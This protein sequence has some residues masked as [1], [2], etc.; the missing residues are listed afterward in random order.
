MLAAKY[1]GTIAG[2]KRTGQGKFKNNRGQGKVKIVNQTSKHVKHFRTQ[3]LAAKYLGVSDASISIAKHQG[4][5]CKG[6]MVYM[7]EKD[8][9]E[10]SINVDN[11]HRNSDITLGDTCD[12]IRPEK[13]SYDNSE[14][15][16]TKNTLD[17]Q[18]DA[19]STFL[20]PPNEKANQIPFSPLPT[21]SPIR[22]QL[23]RPHKIAITTLGSALRFVNFLED[24]LLEARSSLE[25]LKQ[26][27]VEE[28]GTQPVNS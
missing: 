20:A 8:Y 28:F 10:N 1:L 27:I 5:L 19:P 22:S 23:P 11:I 16:M 25:K 24:E 17:P 12:E 4:S 9:Q 13:F 21:T 14:V 2:I 3:G 6:Y 15:C 7:C 18:G 26:Q